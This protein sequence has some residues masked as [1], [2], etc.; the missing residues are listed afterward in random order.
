M[1]KYHFINN[2][3]C[4]RI[5]N[6]VEKLYADFSHQFAKTKDFEKTTN[7]FILELR[8]RLASQEEFTSR[9]C[10]I[11]YS[12][13]FI[14]LVA[15]IF[16]RFNNLGL[17]PGERTPIFDPQEGVIR[18][19]HNIEH[20]LP[21]KPDDDTTIDSATRLLIDN[22]GNLLVLSFRANSSL[23]NLA[24][25]KKMQKLEGELGRKTENLHCVREFVKRYG[26]QAG[27]WNE[28]AIQ[29]RAREM[30]QEAYEKVW[31]LA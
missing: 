28:K 5:G 16:D 30:A 22:I 19:N 1:E 12:D 8:G 14:P 4:S 15:Y 17:A 10:E 11:S 18:K 24:P 26:K 27:E 21:K 23:G 6:E 7:D 2:A 31:K 29:D 9:F 3:V 13:E 20:F 25:D